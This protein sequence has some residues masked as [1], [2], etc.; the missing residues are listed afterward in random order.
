MQHEIKISNVRTSQ[1][2]NV[3]LKKVRYISKYTA[4]LC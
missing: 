1:S 4:N 2:K 3:G